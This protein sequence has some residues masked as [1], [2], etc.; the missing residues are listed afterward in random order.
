MLLVDRDI[1]PCLIDVGSGQYTGSHRGGG[2]FHL[3]STSHIRSDRPTA[4]YPVSQS[5]LTKDLNPRGFCFSAISLLDEVAFTNVI[6]ENSTSAGIP[7]S[8]SVQ[9]RI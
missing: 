2:P 1:P 6:S 3:S 5:Y 8:K 4:T 9:N 7:H